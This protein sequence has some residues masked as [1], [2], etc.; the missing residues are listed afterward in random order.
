MNSR[1]L[2]RGMVRQWL[3]LLL[4][5]SK[6]AF[7]GEPAG[8]EPRQLRRNKNFLG[9]DTSNNF[10]FSSTNSHPAMV[11]PPL[12]D[13]VVE[14]RFAEIYRTPAGPRGLE[15][16]DKVR[17]L[18]GRRVRILGYMVQQAEPAPLTFLFGPAPSK[19]NEEEYGF[20][21]DLPPQTI[22]VHVPS[23]GK[24]LDPLHVQFTPGLLLLTGTL[25]LGEQ[26]EPDGRV[27]YVRLVLDKRK[28]GDLSSGTQ[29]NSN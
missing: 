16:T 28:A 17:S 3:P 26:K 5:A 6:A 11:A 10:R 4:V 15:F 27:S 29:P 20:A 23:A 14:L 21:D 12:P 13:G 25:N 8:S 2:V 1:V 24:E 9:T 19:V 22:H 7:G 18:E